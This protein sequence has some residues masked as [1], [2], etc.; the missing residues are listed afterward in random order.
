MKIDKV[1]TAAPK[2]D[3]WID[4]ENPNPSTNNDDFKGQRSE[5]VRRLSAE[6]KP[7][8]PRPLSQRNLIPMETTGQQT[9]A[10]SYSTLEKI[11]YYLC[12]CW[13]VDNDSL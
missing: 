12:C 6:P 8:T 11:V 1:P 13:N 2:L 9:G 7:D 3:D 4:V 5:I 10:R